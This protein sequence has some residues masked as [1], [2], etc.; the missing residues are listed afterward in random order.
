MDDEKGQIAWICFGLLLSGV[1]GSCFVL[2][3]IVIS[4]GVTPARSVEEKMAHSDTMSAIQIFDQFFDSDQLTRGREIYLQNCAACH[5]A[6]GRGQFP[7]APFQ[8]DSTGR[9]GAPPHNDTGHSWHHSDVLLIRYVTEGGFSD[10]TRFYLMPPFGD[11]LTDE[12]IMLVIAHIKTLWTDEQR[13]RQR[14]LTIEEAQ[15][16]P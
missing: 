3:L 9:I 8:P 14:Q 13:A 7:E 1:M 2:A 11:V 4:G 12:Q 16:S 15:A 5:G 6:E 10:L